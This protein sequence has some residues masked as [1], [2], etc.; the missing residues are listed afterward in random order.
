MSLFASQSSLP[1]L[2]SVSSVPD[3][4][5]LGGGRGAGSEDIA[6]GLF[7][8]VI[9]AKATGIFGKMGANVV[10]PFSG[11]DGRTMFVDERC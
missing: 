9:E 2:K 5:S 1:P 8:L 3:F 10:L 11:E 4:D 7:P 6:L